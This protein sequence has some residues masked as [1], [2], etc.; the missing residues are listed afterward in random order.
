MMTNDVHRPRCLWCASAAGV[1]AMST[2]VR[3][4][5]DATRPAARTIAIIVIAI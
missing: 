3:T 2:I 1:S 5:T 4:G